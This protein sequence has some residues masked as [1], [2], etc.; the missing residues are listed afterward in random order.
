MKL[1]GPLYYSI[2][3][4][5]ALALGV[6]AARGGSDVWD[7]EASAA[8]GITDPCQAQLVSSVNIEGGG[9]RCGRRAGG[10]ATADVTYRLVI[11]AGHGG[12]DRGAQGFL[13]ISEKYLSLEV[14]ELLKRKVEEKARLLALAVQV[15]MTRE[16]DVFQSLHDRVEMANEWPADL[17]LSLHANWSTIQKARGFEVY[18]LSHEA[19]DA[20]A[21]R[22][23]QIENHTEE[24]PIKS[25]ILSILTDVQN[26]K[27]IE[28]SSRLAETIFNRLSLVHTPNGRGVRQ[29]PFTVLSGTSMPSVLIEMGFVSNPN[30]A[31][32]LH[33]PVYLR[34]LA[35]AI[36]AGV[37][38][39]VLRNRK[40][41]TS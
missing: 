12:K 39:F 13:G 29:G 8:P 32:F 19:S 6:T 27:H 34:R 18:F 30:D 35:D 22:L 16:E 37:I 33:N 41:Q 26:T 11:D 31:K 5:P 14:A 28:D 36:S 40:S 25:E 7:L 4:M 10:N 15:K 2:A 9:G 23:V 24:V 21:R 38:D 1:R 20:E 3:L 17:F